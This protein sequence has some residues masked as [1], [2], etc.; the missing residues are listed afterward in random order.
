[1]R[2][3]T[4]DEC[5]LLKECLPEL[6]EQKGVQRIN[7]GSTMARKHGV[8]DLCWIQS[9]QDESFAALSMNNAC[10]IW[11]KSEDETKAFG[12]YR[13]RNEIVNIFDTKESI[14]PSTKP[15]GLFST[16]DDRLCA[17]N[18]A[19]KVSVLHTSKEQ[20][21][22]SFDTV[23]A[24]DQDDPEKPLLTSCTFFKDDNRLAM[25][26]QERD[27]TMWDISSGKEIWKAKNARPDPQTLLQQQVWP[28]SIAFVESNIL[29]VG[30]AHSEIRLYDIRQQRRPIAW[31][32]K[33]MWEHRITAICP[34]PDSTLV[35]GDSAGFLQSLDWRQGL[36]QITGRF[37]GPAGSIRA[38]KAHT[39]ERRLAVVG[40]DR[41][42]RVY[43]Y[44]TRKQM[45]CL[46]LRQRLNCVLFGQK[47][48]DESEQ[49]DADTNTAEEGDWDQDDK[50]E[51]YVDSDDEEPK[52]EGEEYALEGSNSG[53]EE[54]EDDD[55]EASGSEGHSRSESESG[56]NND[57]HS[58][59]EQDREAHTK[60]SKRRKR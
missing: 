35:V 43:D 42:L 38:V 8:I 20:V 32:P 34:L 46:Y 10:S 49:Q 41:M 56:S 58:S 33:G 59:T 53:N 4:G 52:F 30:S 48:S 2:V 29:A 9:E 5:G 11:E 13:K 19:G 37:V 21:V 44:S 31:T 15:L 55:S 27:V 17:C 47:L 60:P 39:K 3:I 16:Q 40:L 26:G 12:K 23:K 7:A 22:N 24:T 51:D 50:I 28:T 1:M 45:H 18:A 57:D 25:G 54:D 14:H 6:G 36:K